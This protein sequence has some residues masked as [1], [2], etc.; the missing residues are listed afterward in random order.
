MLQYIISKNT[1]EQNAQKAAADEEQM[2]TKPVVPKK[3]TNNT[4]K[5]H[6]AITSPMKELHWAKSINLYF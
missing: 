2:G 5:N 3:N 4:K 1:Q 6:P